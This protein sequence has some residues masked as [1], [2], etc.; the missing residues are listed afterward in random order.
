MGP[1]P[2]SRRGVS[3]YYS[4]AGFVS[5]IP[6]ESPRP[7]HQS[8]ASSAAIPSSW[9]SRSP[10]YDYSDYEDEDVQ[11]YSSIHNGTIDEV[12][13]ES[14]GSN[15]DDSDDRGLIRSASFGRR[16]KPSMIVTRNS[17]TASIEKVR[18]LVR[19]QQHIP[20]ESDGS[21]D[22]PI[23]LG[24]APPNMS[25][26]QRDTVWPT[27]DSDPLASGTGLIDASNS[28][29][30][31][32]PTIGTAVT[33]NEPAP[34][35][36]RQPSAPKTNEMLGAYK[37]ASGLSPGS[38]LPLRQPSPLRQASPGFSGLSAIRRPPRLNID[39]VREAEARGSLTSLPDLIARATRLASMMDRGRRPGSRMAVD[40]WG[41][42]DKEMGMGGKWYSSRLM[43][44]ANN[45]QFCATRNT[46][47]VSQACS[48]PSHHQV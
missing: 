38:I 25:A 45:I 12:R 43:C 18:P 4:Q 22:I 40:D 29:S 28:S 26:G 9:G 13:G 41:S 32:V 27:V 10:Q 15:G 19:P 8:Y 48:Q 34:V 23:G 31:T 39:A 5:P 11:D 33:I 20:H 1:P 42:M 36:T 47:Q 7:S 3:S 21:S 35:H 14:R 44:Q 6:E 2:S 30:E 46:N 37:Q 16:A 24:L 17:S